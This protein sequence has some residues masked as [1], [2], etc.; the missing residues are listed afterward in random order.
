VEVEQEE[1]RGYVCT[2][3]RSLTLLVTTQVKG[4]EA[5]VTDS[6]FLGSRMGGWGEHGN[7]VIL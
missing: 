4:R 3:D 2:R 5:V 1:G 7:T 6:Q